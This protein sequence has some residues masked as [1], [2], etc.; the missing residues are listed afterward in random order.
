MMVLNADDARKISTDFNESKVFKDFMKNLNQAEQQKMHNIFG[1]VKKAAMQ[2][3]TSI[4][5]DPQH[6]TDGMLN[7]INFLGYKVISSEL[8]W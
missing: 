1:N 4:I 2:G 6:L 7:F 8:L 5:V 3:D